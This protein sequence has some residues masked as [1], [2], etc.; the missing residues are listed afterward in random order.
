MDH[1][2][3]WE[4]TDPITSP[5]FSMTA[6]ILFCESVWMI[7]LWNGAVVTDADITDVEFDF[8]KVRVNLPSSYLIPHLL[9]PYSTFPVL[10]KI[11]F[12][13]FKREVW[14]KVQKKSIGTINLS[15]IYWYLLILCWFFLFFGSGVIRQMFKTDDISYIFYSNK[16]NNFQFNSRFLKCK[17]CTI[18]SIEIRKQN[19]KL[20]I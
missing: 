14:Q 15:V 20:E 4:E 2:C 5:S 8:L 9:L 7:P 10:Q 6:F 13:F 11:T 19:Y 12:F 1:M 3:A 16:P 17:Q 18:F